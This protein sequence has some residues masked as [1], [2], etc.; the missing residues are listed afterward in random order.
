MPE[1][2]HKRQFLSRFDAVVDSQ[3]RLAIPKAWRFDS[4]PESLE[5]YLSLGPG[6]SLE[7]YEYEEYERR[8]EL[9]E[10]KRIDENSEFVTTASNMYSMTFTLD[11]QGRFI[12]PQH[13]LD[14]AQITSKVYLIGS[15]NFGSIY[16]PEVWARR[17][18][19]LQEIIN[20]NLSFRKSKT[21]VIQSNTNV[22]VVNSE[23]K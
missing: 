14:I 11:K 5:F 16:A 13:I 23:S 4:D 10:Q 18:P 6:P 22:E 15:G 3:R 19:A 2:P 9:Q 1:K 8:L 21:T 20:Y 12:L 7:F 17:E